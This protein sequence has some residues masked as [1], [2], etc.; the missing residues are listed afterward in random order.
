MKRTDGFT[1]HW[2]PDWKERGTKTG[3]V[4]SKRA[5]TGMDRRTGGKNLKVDILLGPGI[6]QEGRG[7]GNRPRANHA[8]H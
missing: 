1:G 8:S 5:E 6:F 3:T 7:T 4:S 2:R